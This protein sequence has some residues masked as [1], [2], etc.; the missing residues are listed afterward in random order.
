[1]SRKKAILEAAREL[2]NEKEKI[3]ERA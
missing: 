1:M 2:F 3:N